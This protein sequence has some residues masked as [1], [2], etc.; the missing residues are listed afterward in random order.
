MKFITK[1]KN[2]EEKI[3]KLSLEQEGHAVALTATDEEGV[4][5]NLMLFENGKFVRFD[6][7][8]TDIGIEVDKEGRILEDN[9]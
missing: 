9:N 3:V 8:H 5:W 6:S 4:K 7:V 2:N 1:D